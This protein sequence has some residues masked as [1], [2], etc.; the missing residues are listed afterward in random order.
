VNYTI[1][2]RLNNSTILS[3]E[4]TLLHNQTWERPVRYALEKPGDEQKLEFL[5][6][7]ERNFT[8]PYGD[9]HLRVNVS[10]S[11][12]KRLNPETFSIRNLEM[13]FQQPVCFHAQRCNATLP[14]P[15]TP[16]T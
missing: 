1:Q 15:L 5:L 3:Q 6:F 11:G 10:D 4:L 9:L 2:L 12:T 8:A 7:K 16:Y 13:D 14:L